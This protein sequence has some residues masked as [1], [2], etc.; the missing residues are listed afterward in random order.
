MG[1]FDPQKSNVVLIPIW[2]AGTTQELVDNGIIGRAKVIDSSKY[3]VIAVESFGNGVAPSPSNSSLQHGRGFPQ[4]SIRDMVRTQQILLTR[5]LAIDH[6]HAVVGISMGGM[7]A[8]LWMVMYPD[9]MDEVIPICASP[10]MTSNNL[11]LWAAEL[12]I[13]ENFRDCKAGAAAM[14]IV[15]P[16]HTLL[17]CN[18]RFRATATKTESLP[19]FLHELENSFRQYDATNWACQVKAI[20]NQDILAGFQGSAEKAA[21]S[22]HAK[23]LIVSSVQD[24]IVYP[25]PASLFARLVKAEP[26]ELTR[27]CGHLAFLCDR[28]ELRVIVDGFLEKKGEGIH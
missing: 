24:Q 1:E 27:D 4:F 20:M 3:C 15:A 25:E 13:L 17:V 28:E 26:A 21:K 2:L 11:L 23:V 19:D 18:P 5:H 10:W 9:F 22:V 7:Q 8:F 6:L 16:M 12:G 14:K